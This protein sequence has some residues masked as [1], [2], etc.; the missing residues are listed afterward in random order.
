MRGILMVERGML[1]GPDV[2]VGHDCLERI[3]VC[4]WWNWDGGSTL[5]LCRWAP[6]I[7]NWVHDGTPLWFN[8]D[9]APYY[10]RPQRGEADP[11]MRGLLKRKLKTVL[12]RRYLEKEYVKSLT[13][14][15]GVSKG[16]DDIRVVF[17]GTGSGLNAALWAPWFSLPTSSSLARII[18]LILSWVMRTLGRC[19]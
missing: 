2:I 3:V 16:T 13:T 12:D 9:M 7:R 10:R 11:V 5:F 18:E 14:F 4:S 1:N 6:E 17:D 8:S 15:F 19:F